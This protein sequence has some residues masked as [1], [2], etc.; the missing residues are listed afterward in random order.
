MFISFDLDDEQSVYKG[1]GTSGQ[2]ADYDDNNGDFFKMLM[3]TIPG[4]PGQDYP[5]LEMIPKTSFSC[6]GRVFGGF[7]AD[8]ASECQ[9]EIKLYFLLE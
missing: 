3:N 5:V 9:V 8:P 7:Y 6:K 1:S 4:T 2:Q